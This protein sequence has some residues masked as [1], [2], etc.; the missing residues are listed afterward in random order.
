M[1]PRSLLTI[2]AATGALAFAGCGDGSPT[3]CFGLDATN[4]A[5]E[6]DYLDAFGTALDDAARRELKVRVLLF[7]GDPLTESTILSESFAGLGASE[8]AT[9]RR[10]RVNRVRGEL[11]DLLAD[12]QAGVAGAAEGSAIVD[13][14]NVLVTTRGECDTLDVYTDG[15]ERVRFS[16][17]DDAITT[18]GDREK[19]VATLRAE[20][21]LPDMGG[22]T[23]RFPYGGFV[24][25][26]SSL[27]LKRKE[28]L[29][30][31]WTTVVAGFGG[32]AEWG[33]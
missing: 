22:V 8:L 31:L 29:D 19:I 7:R 5:I 14:M 28:A 4:P 15:L 10:H 23:V 30:P 16:V 12:V 11:D 18:G 13:A 24:I 2:A 17:Y 6:T 20:S 32:H 33:S 26:S 27:P 3:A 21:A 9:Q 25:G 1:R